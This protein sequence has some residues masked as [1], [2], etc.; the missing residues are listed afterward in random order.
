M[1]STHPSLNLRKS[2]QG[3]PVCQAPATPVY[4]PLVK[5]PHGQQKE[6]TLPEARAAE[7]GKAA[8]KTEWVHV[9][10]HR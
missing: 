3:L 10:S 8:V 9:C 7:G 5:P 2:D 1:P 6:L 4:I